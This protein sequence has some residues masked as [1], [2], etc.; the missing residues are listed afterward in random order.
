MKGGKPFLETPDGCY[1]VVRGRLWRKSKPYHKKRDRLLPGLMIARPATR[2][3]PGD[4]V[5]L[6]EVALRAP[7]EASIGGPSS[8]RERMRRSTAKE[9][10]ELGQSLRSNNSDNPS[11][12]M[13]VIVVPCR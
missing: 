10:R 7:P 12:S 9:Q 5:A 3:P 11:S 6:D 2:T 4:E 1:I 8:D 13:R